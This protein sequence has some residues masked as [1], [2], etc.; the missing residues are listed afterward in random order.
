MSKK[1]VLS[2][3]I[4]CLFAGWLAMGHAQAKEAPGKSQAPA[5]LTIMTHDS[6]SISKTVAQAF[7]NRHNVTLKFLKAGDA[8][9]ALNQAILSRNNPM[10]DV[11]FGVDNAFLSRAL[12]ADMFEPYHSPLLKN[13]PER[14]KLDKSQRLTPIDFGDV[15]INYDKKWFADKK[16]PPPSTM[17]DLAKPL[18][19]S[20][21]VVENPATSSP[22]LAF[23]L[24]TISRFGEVGQM[25]FW[26]KL[27]KN[28]ALVVNG[29]NE[30]YW[31]KFTAA[32]KG[33]RPIVVSYATSPAAEVF[34]SKEKISSPPTAAITGPGEC[35]RQ[36]EFAG[37]FARSKNKETAKKFMDF[38][39]DIPFQEDI[40]LNMFV[41][42]VNPDAKLPDVF[43]AHA[44]KAEKPGVVG[45]NKIAE[46]RME[47]ID[48]WTNEMLR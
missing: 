43:A 15:C 27:K 18:Y 24:A 32:S 28:N 37:I 38:M 2:V 42:P 19:E 12:S 6:F 35:F 4:L 41:F 25:D 17:E 29:W 30:A 36:I 9:A 1:T 5:T 39:L 7:E 13:I 11:F 47:W 16:I 20:L 31:G 48:A 21:L 3:F 8:G 26:R 44:K 45:H 40:P 14:F 23:L 22:G 33:D 46:K 10:A 34:F